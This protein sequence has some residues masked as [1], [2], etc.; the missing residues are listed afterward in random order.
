MDNHPTS[1]PPAAGLLAVLLG[2][3]A[4][5]SGL[6]AAILPP[7]GGL[8]ALGGLLAFAL[9]LALLVAL[10]FWRAKKPLAGA[11]YEAPRSTRVRL[12][13]T[14]VTL[15]F[16]VGVMGVVFALLVRLGALRVDVGLDAVRVATALTGLYVLALGIVARQAILHREAAGGWHVSAHGVLVG[17]F[18][19]PA[20]A[21][22]VVAAGGQGIQLGPWVLGVADLHVQVLVAVLGVGTQTFLAARLP[23]TLDVAKGLSRLLVGRE[24]PATQTPPVVYAVL[25]AL[26]ATLLFGVTFSQLRL[27]DR[28]GG[29]GSGNLGLAIV[30]VPLL[31]VIFLGV[32][33]LQIRRESQRGLY[34][35][36]LEPQAKVSLAVYAVSAGL[37]SLTAL[38][39]AGNLTG[40]FDGLPGW[41]PSGS[42]LSKD[43]IM[44][45][46]VTTLGPIG[47]H[48]SRRNR[49][50]DAIDTRLP[51]FLNDLAE[52]R[53]AGLTMEAALRS[54]ATT[55]YG[56][57]SPEVQ[58]MSQQVAWGVGFVEAL[59]QFSARVKTSLVERSA[60]LVIE[61][62]KTGGSVAEIL[63]SAARDA[64]EL[65]ALRH[66][67]RVTM[68]TYL[69]VLYVV[70]AVF[71]GVL[72]ALDGQFIPKILEAGQAA[73][74]AGGTQAPVGGS[75]G[76]LDEEAF[77]FAYFNA[78]IVQAIGNG[79][80]AGVLTEG[81]FA[82]G[83]R[84]ISIMAVLAWVVFRLVL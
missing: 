55:D 84:H 27:V 43:L 68:A 80:V 78:A 17:V 77:R 38:L 3:G 42:D 83:F 52:T 29:L 61:A 66:E 14:G 82:G 73:A 23:T 24:G 9:P 45:T 4:A 15:A 28:L 10:P 65:N 2:A 58:K 56:L 64:Q 40:R 49:R 71:L 60:H 47:M 39:L 41:L 72:A 6:A 7:P 11:G 1:T 21:L 53:R 18:G 70:F 79:L 34:T 59:K 33:V 51:D 76:T 5:V 8:L 13:H 81:R 63:K 35:K 36:R 69:V 48:L 37:G 12:L 26:G 67:R 44:L 46:L 19:L 54:C 31:L 16:N 30:L 22:I 25:L 75:I 32:S 20:L 74:Q 50:L 57:L 62:S